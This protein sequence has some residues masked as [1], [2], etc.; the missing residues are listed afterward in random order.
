MKTERVKINT[1]TSI[2]HPEWKQFKTD[3]KQYEAA[4]NTFFDSTCYYVFHNQYMRDIDEAKNICLRHK[5][6][7]FSP[8]SEKHLKQIFYLAE[9]SEYYISNDAEK[10]QLFIISDIIMLIH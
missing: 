7:P 9:N 6:E 1:K 10:S 2:C 8:K 3:C 5:L 4:D